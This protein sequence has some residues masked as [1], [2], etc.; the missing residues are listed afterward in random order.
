MLGHFKHEGI[1]L[2][3]SMQAEAD[4]WV[5][6][7]YIGVYHVVERCPTKPNLT[8]AVEIAKGLAPAL[9]DMVRGEAA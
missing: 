5:V 7:T 4:E 2:R 1:G 6:K 3:W 9:L 8:R